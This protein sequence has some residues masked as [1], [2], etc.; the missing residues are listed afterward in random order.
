MNED[1]Q[2]DDIMKKVF[3]REYSSFE[4]HKT[5]LEQSDLPPAELLQGYIELL[6]AYRL[7]L[8]DAV[9]ITKIGDINQKKLFDVNNELEKQKKL[10]YLISITDALTETYNRTFL[11]QA[12]VKEF[13]K[14][15]RYNQVFSCI[16]IDV[17]DFKAINDNYGHQVGDIV[18]SEVANL[19]KDQIREVDSF[20]RYGGEEFMIILPNTNIDQ[21]KIVAE[22]VRSK[23]EQQI[24]DIKNHAIRLTISQGLS[25]ISIDQP[26]TED[27]LLYKVD[28]ALY[29]A[30]AQGKNRSVVFTPEYESTL[31]K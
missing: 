9:K 14:S 6:N 25:D 20:G 15:Q 17:D 5:L 3:K 4:K 12:L 29:Q 27:E 23:I 8:Q 11:M 19:I 7:L 24:F 21:A 26:Q 31:K 13:A 1:E 30:K 16:L 2:I 22:K 28:T 10:L 18:L